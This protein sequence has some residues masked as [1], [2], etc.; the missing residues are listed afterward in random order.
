MPTRVHITW[1]LKGR[2]GEEKRGLT[3]GLCKVKNTQTIL[4]PGFKNK[5]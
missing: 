1:K 2:S 4:K 3:L 5:L